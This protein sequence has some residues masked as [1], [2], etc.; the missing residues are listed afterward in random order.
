MATLHDFPK[1]EAGQRDI[2]TPLW[3]AICRGCAWGFDDIKTFN[4]VSARAAAHSAVHRHDV[5]IRFSVIDCL[6]EVIR[7]EDTRR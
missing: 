3:K 1:Q 5:E 7:A 4:A 2:Y 6:S